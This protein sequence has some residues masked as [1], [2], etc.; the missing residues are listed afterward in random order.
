L[1]WASPDVSKEIGRFAREANW[2]IDARLFYTHEVPLGWRGDGLIATFGVRADLNRFIRRQAPLQPTV[3][4]GGNNGGLFVPT[5]HVDNGAVG[6]LAA[7]HL[8]E[9]NHQNFAWFSTDHGRVAKDRCDGFVKAIRAKG[10]KCIMLNYKSSENSVN[11]N[12]RRRWLADRLR[13][14]PRQLAIFALD[15]TLA[16]ETIEV[17][18][19]QGW[20]VP[21]EISV[22]GAG[23]LDIAC[24]CSHIPITSVDTREAE[25]AW[26]A[27]EML[28]QMMKG[29]RGPLEV[30][31]PP[32]PIVI[33][34]S[35]DTLAAIHPAIRKAIQFMKENISKP[36]GADAIALAA[37]I[38]RRALYEFFDR[39][40]NTTPIVI[41]ASFRLERARNRL[42][43]TGDTISTI[44]MHCGFGTHR[45]LDRIFL[46]VEGCTPA[47]WRE[48]IRSKLH[49]PP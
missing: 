23:N 37:G 31:L 28:E 21:G 34:Q 11:W 22:I 33:R 39:E 20:E 24:E 27:A 17:C 42:L 6:R 48:K 38:S 25:V 29:K 4:L 2:R 8:L 44:A 45:T 13:A 15:D 30:I 14:L 43:R 1:G 19:E 5:V 9:R 16:S 49:S 36:F 18:R 41:L 40:L 10:H 46:K 47:A 7:G 32:G 35:S 26:R 12:H 3:I